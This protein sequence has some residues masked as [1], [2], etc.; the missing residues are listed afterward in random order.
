MK[1]KTFG[2]HVARATVSKALKRTAMIQPQTDEFGFSIRA[3][4][5]GHDTSGGALTA[6]RSSDGRPAG[7]PRSSP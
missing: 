1:K 6:H 3:L 4:N 5:D 7:V 2:F